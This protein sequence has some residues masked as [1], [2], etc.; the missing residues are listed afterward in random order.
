MTCEGVRAPFTVGLEAVQISADNCSLT[1][2]G[3]NVPPCD[4]AFLFSSVDALVT[5]KGVA[6]EMRCFLIS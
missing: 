3:F 6:E 1:P 5:G 4:T 2:P